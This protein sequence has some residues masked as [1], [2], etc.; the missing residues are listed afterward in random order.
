MSLYICINDYFED[1]I[2][3]HS[4]RIKRVAQNTAFLYVRMIFVMCI[5]IYTSRVILISLGASDYG[6]YNVVGG[7]VVMFSFL[8]GSMAGATSRFLAFELAKDNKKQLNATFSASLNLYLIAGLLVVIL[9][10]IVGLY[11]VNYKLTIPPDRMTAA[12]YVLHFSIITSFFVLTQYPYT[13]TIIAH[14]EM[15]I[16]AY[17]GIY[18]AVSKLFVAWFIS[19]SSCD[20]LIFYAALIMVNQILILAFYRIFCQRRFDECHFCMVNDKSLYKKLLGYT[21]YDMIPSAAMVV[22]N[23]GVNILLN[24]FFGPVVN[25]ARAIAFQIDGAIL[26][27]TNNFLQAVRPQIIKQYAT[28]EKESMYKLSFSASKYSYLI[29]LALL[30]PVIME[31]DYILSVWLGEVVPDKTTLFCYIILLMGTIQPLFSPMWMVVQAIGKLRNFSLVN[32]FLYLIPLPIGYL[33][34]KYG[35]SDYT[36][37]LAVL[38]SASLRY[39]YSLIQL[40]WLEKFDIISYLHTVLGRCMIISFLSVAVVLFIKLQL[41]EGFL[42]LVY[43]ILTS[44]ASIAF[45]TWSLG[46]SSMERAHVK[47]FI[48]KKF[49]N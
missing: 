28:G 42:R 40:Y 2:M 13:A 29:M 35:F 46:M 39:V 43:I 1:T 10:E 26:Q 41:N 20:R 15:G 45:F 3:G 21:G 34:F 30:L 11:F 37:L 22:Q 14:E 25:T 36:I 49:I 17:V 47:L 48:Y 16:Y 24:M 18:E 6:V 9:G 12:F 33:F 27:F 38:A 19:V 31:L 8:T 4:F 23:Q 44:E 5:T 32:S 7:I